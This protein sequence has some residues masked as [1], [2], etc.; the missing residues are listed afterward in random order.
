[1]EPPE[2][3][4]IRSQDLHDDGWIQPRLVVDQD[5]AEPDALPDRPS[6][7]VWQEA[8][9]GQYPECVGTAFGYTKTPVRN[10]MVRL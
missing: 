8:A 7:I 4:H 1:M 5:V 2:G 6:Q 10:H 3:L 9:F